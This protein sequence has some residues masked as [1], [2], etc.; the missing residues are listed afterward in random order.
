[1]AEIKKYILWSCSTCAWVIVISMHTNC[2]Y[3]ALK[4]LQNIEALNNNMGLESHDGPT[5]MDIQDDFFTQI[6]GTLVGMTGIVGPVS[7]CLFHMAILDF[8]QYG[9]FR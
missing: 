9:C 6:F 5:G 2:F 8:S 4:P 3:I 7:T 1:M